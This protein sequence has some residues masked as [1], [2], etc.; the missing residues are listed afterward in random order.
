MADGIA[1]EQH[2]I[3]G[4]FAEGAV[5]PK[6]DLRVRERLVG[7]VPAGVGQLGAHLESPLCKH[8]EGGEIMLDELVAPRAD[9]GDIVANQGEVLGKREVKRL[10]LRG[11]GAGAE[12]ARIV[13]GH[14]RGRAHPNAGPH[15]ELLHVGG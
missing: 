10:L 12:P 5:E 13:D 15:P 1:S 9:A 11:A 7:E 4:A 14:E 2:G 6:D 3:T 8:V